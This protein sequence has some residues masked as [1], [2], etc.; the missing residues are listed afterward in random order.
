VSESASS[1][2]LN[3]GNTPDE[4]DMGI[5]ENQLAISTRLRRA[6]PLKIGISND[7]AESSEQMSFT[8]EKIF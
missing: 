2:L 8:V 6:A 4:S 7:E 1:E 5:S 3:T